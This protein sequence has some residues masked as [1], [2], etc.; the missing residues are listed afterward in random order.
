MNTTKSLFAYICLKHRRRVTLGYAKFTLF[1][2]DWFHTLVHGKPATTIDWSL[3]LWTGPHWKYQDVISRFKADSRFM[4]K[5]SRTYHGVQYYKYLG[6]KRDIELSKDLKLIVD[7]I[8]KGRDMYNDLHSYVF[9]SYPFRSS[10]SRHSVD[11]KE[12][13]RDYKAKNP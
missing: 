7:K 10:V 2:V 11:F 6:K 9:S 8:L 4:I 3:S 1:L 12:I 5:D 13:A